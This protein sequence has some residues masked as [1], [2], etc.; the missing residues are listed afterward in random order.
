MR[1]DAAIPLRGLTESRAKAAAAITGGKVTVNGR[2]VTKPSYPVSEED[3]IRVLGNEETYVSRA[4]IKLA[5][6]L[7][8]FGTSPEGKTVLDVGASTGG[9]TDCLLRRGAAYVFAVDV[10]TDQLHPSLRNDPRVRNMEKTNARTLSPDLFDR[11]V[12]MAVMDVSFISQSFLYP[13][14]SGVLPAGA[15]LITLVKPQFEAG[16]GHVGK[17]GIVRDP[18]GKIA[19]AVM[20]RLTE[21]ADGSGF[22]LL[23]TIVSP[24]P[25]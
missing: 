16:P 9:F 10:G 13:A 7:D 25:G 15:P 19:R 12:D 18:D 2:T 5:A 4:G 24:V 22:S 3:E 23:R 11:P 17:N 8:A 20:D 14:L 1:L 21:A 6:A